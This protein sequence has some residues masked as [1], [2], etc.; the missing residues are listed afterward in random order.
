[1]LRHRWAAPLLSIAIAAAPA[2]RPAADPSF[3]RFLDDGHGGGQMQVA[4]ASYA[5]G[6]GVTV[7]L[8]STIHIG[9]AP[10]FRQLAKRLT[11]YDAIL[12]ELV[13][14]KGQPAVEE[15]VNPQQAQIAGEMSLDN[16]GPHMNYDRPAYVHADLDL[17]D[18]QKQELAA[19]GTTKGMLGEGPGLS[20][21]ASP[22]DTAGQVNVFRDMRAAKAA[23]PTNRR[24]YTRLMRRAYARELAFEA[25]PA[26]GTTY[27][28]GPDMDI[29]VG[30]RNRHVMSVLDEQV[31]KGRRHVAILYG[32]AHMID[33]ESRLLA[34]GYRRQSLEWTTAWTVAPDG[35]PT[36]KPAGGLTKGK[37]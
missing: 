25:A 27:P 29:L 13:G 8:V 1:M 5:N 36:T 24:E 37:R 22:A 14:H 15:G 30:N 26:P 6:D 20:S 33:L 31:E 32:A 34:H 3:V 18:L 21:A 28:A 2:T 9:D 11:A 23:K 16:Q 17:E 4:V 35:T 12:Y 10:F 7:D 19:H